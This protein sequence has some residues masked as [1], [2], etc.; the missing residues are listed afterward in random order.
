MT[1]FEEGKNYEA[2]DCGLDPITVIRRTPKMILV[3]NGFSQWRMRLDTDGEGNEVVTDKS[4]PRK[5]RYCF[6]YSSKLERRY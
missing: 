5:W 4:V 2:Y 3:T 1:V 6:T